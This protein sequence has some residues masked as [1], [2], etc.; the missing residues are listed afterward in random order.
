MSIPKCLPTSTRRSSAQRP[1]GRV[2]REDQLARATLSKR[3]A[4]GRKFLAETFQGRA[5]EWFECEV[6]ELGV[7]RFEALHEKV[8]SP[9]PS[10]RSS[11]PANT[12]RAQ[13]ALLDRARSRQCFPRPPCRGAG[14]KRSDP[15]H[16]IPCESLLC[17]TILPFSGGRERE[18]R[19]PTDAP[20]RL[21]CRVRRNASTGSRRLA[22]RSHRRHATPAG[23]EGQA[24]ARSGEP[25]G[26]SSG[27]HPPSSPHNPQKPRDRA[28]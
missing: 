14:G 23:A 11:H 6:V 3:V 20:V 9:N 15:P 4:E 22:L 26:A 21:Q 1:K 25:A 13:V 7:G 2:V 5:I 18:A 24:M 10:G 12:R 19:A 8:R 27:G 28:P 17:P 16:C